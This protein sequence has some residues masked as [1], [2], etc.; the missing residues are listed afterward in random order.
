VADVK[1]VRVTTA[2]GIDATITIEYEDGS[3]QIIAADELKMPSPLDPSTAKLRV[4]EALR[5]SG[6]NLL[7]INPEQITILWK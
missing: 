6:V 4:A 7:F 3:T 2:N 5:K 1:E